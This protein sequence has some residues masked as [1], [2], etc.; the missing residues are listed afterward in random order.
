MWQEKPP[1]VIKL[2]YLIWRDAFHLLK[3]GT[4]LVQAPGLALPGMLETES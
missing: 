1:R 4:L 3:T 2:S